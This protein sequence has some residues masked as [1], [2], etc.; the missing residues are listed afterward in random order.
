MI[1]RPLFLTPISCSAQNQRIYCL[2][3]EEQGL[4]GA[5]KYFIDK[6]STTVFGCGNQ[7]FGCGSQIC[8]CGS[9]IFGCGNLIFSCDNLI[10]SCGNQIFGCGNW[11][12]GGGSQTF[13]CGN[14]IFGCGDQ[15]LFCC[16]VSRRVLFATFTAV[17]WPEIAW[18]KHLC[19]AVSNRLRSSLG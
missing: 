10:F 2:H 15:M 4:V 14:Q 7:G 12:F 18:Q 16:W 19:K 13:G 8:G 3:G 17:P 11:I 5:T 6:Y 9:Q 1:I